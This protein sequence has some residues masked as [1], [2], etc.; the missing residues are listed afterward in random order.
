MPVFPDPSATP[1]TSTAPSAQIEYQP[2]CCVSSLPFPLSSEAK[3]GVNLFETLILNCFVLFFSQSITYPSAFL[4][5][6]I[7]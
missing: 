7:K 1:L 2:V 4:N 6:Y 3:T 5:V